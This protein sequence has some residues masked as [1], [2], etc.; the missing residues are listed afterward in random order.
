MKIVREVLDRVEV[1]GA[2]VEIARLLGWIEDQLHVADQVQVTTVDAA[3][4]QLRLTAML[5]RVQGRKLAVKLYAMGGC[6]D[7]LAMDGSTIEWLAGETIAWLEAN[8]QSLAG[9]ER[10]RL[11]EGLEACVHRRSEI[12]DGEDSSAA[13]ARAEGEAE[14]AQADDGKHCRYCGKQ[15]MGPGSAPRGQ[16]YVCWPLCRPAREAGAR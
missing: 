5:D 11:Q 13:C 1:E 10:A 8:G 12:R 16:P 2:P 9:S 14:E 6:G 3:P 4:G 15:R 7:R